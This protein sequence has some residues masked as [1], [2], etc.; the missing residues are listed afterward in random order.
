MKPRE[1]L[2]P[3]TDGI[4][5]LNIYSR[6]RTTEGRLLSNFAET[7]FVLDGVRFASVEAWYQAPRFDHEA[8]RRKVAGMSG[9]SCKKLGDTQGKK[10][11]APVRLF[12][13]RVVP[14]DGADYRAAFGQAIRA[15]VAQNP[16]VRNALLATESLPLT[17]LLCDDGSTGHAPRRGW[18]ARRTHDR[19]PR[20]AAA[21]GRGPLPAWT[22]GRGRSARP[23]ATSARHGCRSTL[24]GHAGAGVPG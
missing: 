19:H 2:S 6:G 9:A 23:A 1:L 4:D 13:G 7:P 17:H 8:M 12:D 16:D 22:A 15:K 24:P 10:A 21:S 18:R 11:G 14:Y 20:R 3:R 5:H